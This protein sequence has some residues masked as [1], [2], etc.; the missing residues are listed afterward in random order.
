MALGTN[1]HKKMIIVNG[2]GLE[3]AQVIWIKQELTQKSF[4]SKSALFRAAIDLLRNTTTGPPPNEEKQ[5][6]S[7]ELTWLEISTGLVERE[8]SDEE[9]TMAKATFTTL[10]DLLTLH[11]DDVIFDYFRQNFKLDEEQAIRWVRTK[12][13][14]CACVASLVEDVKTLESLVDALN[15]RMKKVKYRAKSQDAIGF[16]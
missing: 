2:I 16:Q 3:E 10:R 6:Q 8:L 7:D 13:V 11:E 1:P 4:K 12:L 14:K 5:P 15:S 9:E